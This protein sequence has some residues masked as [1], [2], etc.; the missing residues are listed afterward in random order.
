MYESLFAPR[1]RNTLVRRLA[2]IRAQFATDT[3][4]ILDSVELTRELGH[5]MSQHGIALRRLLKCVAQDG[6][7]KIYEIDKDEWKAMLAELNELG[8]KHA[9][10]TVFD[11]NLQRQHIDLVLR[12]SAA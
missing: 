12:V 11:T 2:W 1:I 4:A 3:I 7:H 5:P 10:D 8:T 6:V 9:I